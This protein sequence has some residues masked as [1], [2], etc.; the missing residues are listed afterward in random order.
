MVMSNIILVVVRL[1][2]LVVGMASC[3]RQD[4]LQ[5]GILQSPTESYVIQKMPLDASRGF[6]LHH[7][8]KFDEASSHSNDMGQTNRLDSFTAVVIKCLDN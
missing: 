2:V 5:V 3:S 7:S 8:K 4:I 6:L 1:S